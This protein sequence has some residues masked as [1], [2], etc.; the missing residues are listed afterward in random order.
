MP[1]NRDLRLNKFQLLA[2]LFWK[3]GDA[4]IAP[5]TSVN[6]LPNV[7]LSNPV[8]WVLGPA[9]AKC[10][11]SSKVLNVQYGRAFPLKEPYNCCNNATRL[12]PRLTINGLTVDSKLMVI[13]FFNVSID[14]GPHG[15][16][17]RKGLV[18]TA[19]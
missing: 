7:C 2:A 13:L 12:R 9:N 14:K 16:V 6:S 19:T 5:T 1:V 15:T 18:A 17:G 8:H 10:M 11:S 4:R 3:R